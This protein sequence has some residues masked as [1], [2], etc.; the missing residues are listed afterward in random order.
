[1]RST[2]YNRIFAILHTQIDCFLLFVQN[3][4]IV[5]SARAIAL[6]SPITINMHL[7]SDKTWLILSLSSFCKHL[8]HFRIT[9]RLQEVAFI[10]GH[11]CFY[12]YI[13]VSTWISLR[14]I[15]EYFSTMLL[16]QFEK[17]TQY[18]QITNEFALFLDA[19]HPTFS[20]LNFLLFHFYW[21]GCKG[22]K[23][24][25]VQRKRSFVFHSE[26]ASTKYES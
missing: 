26:G 24:D 9:K 25:Q 8:E 1:M 18:S 3:L 16:M 10:N 5:A 20:D 22:I 21:N 12:I 11:F 23:L 19:P 6:D 14:N 7:K 15:F 17:A 13:K 4:Q 2:G